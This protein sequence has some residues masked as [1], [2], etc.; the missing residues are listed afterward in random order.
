M[1]PI[2]HRANGSVLD[3][4][5]RMKIGLP[6]AKRDDVTALSGER[7]DF[8]QYDE[9]ILGSEIRGAAADGGHERFSSKPREEFYPLAACFNAGATR[10]LL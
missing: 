9:S 4:R 10:P 2:A 1:P 3:M 6:D 5:G 7:I 8:G